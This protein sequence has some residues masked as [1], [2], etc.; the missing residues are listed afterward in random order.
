MGKP[1]TL[2]NAS[3]HTNF[4]YKISDF[5]KEKMEAVNKIN[6]NKKLLDRIKKIYDLNGKIEFDKIVSN[7]LEKN[8]KLIDSNMDKLMANALLYSY[9][10]NE[11]DL[12]KTFFEANLNFNENFLK[13]KLLDFLY[14]ICFGFFPSIEWNGKYSVNGGIIISKDNGEVVLLDKI[15]HNDLLEEYLYS[16]CKFE[17]PSSSRYHM[18]DIFEE[19]NEFFFTLNLQIRSKK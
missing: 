1:A 18:L 12:Q 2:L 11:K 19:N 16:S 15:Y 4:R 3:A 10:K 6:T 8:L 13:K 9:S 14:G 7:T 17:S 5:N